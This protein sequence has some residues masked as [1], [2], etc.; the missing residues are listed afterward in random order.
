MCIP[1]KARGGQAGIDE[2]FRHVAF[3]AD[4]KFFS[5][6]LSRAMKANVRGYALVPDRQN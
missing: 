2:V 3:H 5:F 6:G 1:F 4:A